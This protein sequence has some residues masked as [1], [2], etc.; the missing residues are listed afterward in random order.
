MN[1]SGLLSERISTS[2]SGATPPINPQ[3]EANLIS[4]LFAI[5][6][7]KNSLF[8]L[9]GIMPSWA[10]FPFV[11]FVTTTLWLI[12]TYL[13]PSEDTSVLRSFYKKTQP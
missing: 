4:L 10:E 9:G 5:P 11:V 1:K 6:S 7:I 8:G 13:T 2:I 12:V 3:K